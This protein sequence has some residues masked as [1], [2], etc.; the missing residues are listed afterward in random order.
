MIGP[1][2]RLES[3][4]E[5]G[6]LVVVPA[7]Q[8]APV[9]GGM[10]RVGGLGEMLPD[11]GGVAHPLVAHGQFVVGQA[12]QSRIARQFSEFERPCVQGNCPRLLAAFEGEAPVQ[13][14]QRRQPGIR[15]RL[16]RDV[17]RPPEC[18]WGSSSVLT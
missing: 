13:A 5:V 10:E 16:F 6:A 17:R 12:N 3:C 8:V 15:K 11:D 7:G 9:A 4:P 1:D 18:G 2:T 14:P